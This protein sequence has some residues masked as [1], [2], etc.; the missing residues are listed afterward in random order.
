VLAT[1]DWLA[2]IVQKGAI[3][4]ENIMAH[5]SVPDQRLLGPNHAKFARLSRIDGEPP[6]REGGVQ[7]LA[8]KATGIIY[9]IIWRLVLTKLFKELLFIDSKCA[10]RLTQYLNRLAESCKPKSFKSP[11]SLRMR[12]YGLIENMR[13][14]FS[15]SGSTRSSGDGDKKDWRDTQREWADR[16]P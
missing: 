3:D 15:D 5:R 10:L 7:K 2:A 14:Q 8:Y 9:P 13:E 16:R 6:L 12:L 4:L 1:D 11:Q